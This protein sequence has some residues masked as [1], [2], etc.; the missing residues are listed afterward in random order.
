MTAPRDRV[1][2]GTQPTIPLNNY[3]QLASVAIQVSKCENHV[4]TEVDWASSLTDVNQG[5]S[6][7][8]D[9]YF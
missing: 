5:T 1:T 3:I 7:S 8:N 2:R 9:Y 4:T 6:S